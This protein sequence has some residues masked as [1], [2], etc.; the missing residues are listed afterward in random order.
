MIEVDARVKA[1]ADTCISRWAF[2]D[3]LERMR[4]ISVRANCFDL[5]SNSKEMT[6]QPFN[7][8]KQDLDLKFIQDL[9]DMEGTT[10]VIKRGQR[11]EQE[12]ERAQWVGYV[13]QGC[14]KYIKR[15]LD[16]R[17]EHVNG[18][19][20]EHEF[21]AEYPACIYG[22]P[23]RVSIEAVVNSTVR[24]VRGE[25]L[26]ELYRESWEATELGRV[27]TEHLFDQTYERMNNFY[28]ADARQR[29]YMLLEYCPQVIQQLPLKDIASFVNVTPTYISKIRREHTFGKTEKF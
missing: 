27:I 21:V 13:E 15:S 10:T 22:H 26:L 18:F 24:L 20:F 16:G 8:Y 25:R 19:V 14:F 17:H 6:K 1:R 4:E 28:C 9:C 5:H 11:L 12:G 7:T 3:A 2:G 29:Y 23:S